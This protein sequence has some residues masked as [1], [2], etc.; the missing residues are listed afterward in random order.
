MTYLAAATFL[1]AGS[2]Q[3]FAQATSLSDLLDLVENDRVAESERYLQRVQEFEQNANRQQE[4]LDKA[5][6][7][8]EK[9]TQIQPDN[10]T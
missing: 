5:E 2:T 8:L 4:I 3:V 10:P 9:A 7:H 1:L 6:P